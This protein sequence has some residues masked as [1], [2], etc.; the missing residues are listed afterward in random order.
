MDLSRVRESFIGKRLQRAIFRSQPEA[1]YAHQEEL[2]FRMLPE[3]VREVVEIIDFERGGA[4]WSEHIRLSEVLGIPLETLRNSLE[5]PPAN[6][7]A[8]ERSPTA[9][10]KSA[11][12]VPGE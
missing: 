11:R 9:A 1:L 10:D 6:E 5:T 4:V 8:R 3:L 2:V 7:K 12:L